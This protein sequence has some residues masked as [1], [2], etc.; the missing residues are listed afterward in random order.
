MSNQSLSI[1][2]ISVSL[3]SHTFD[4][5]GLISGQSSVLSLTIKN[6][7]NE[8][9]SNANVQIT[10]ASDFTSFDESNID[11]GNIAAVN[12]KQYQQQ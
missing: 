12:L 1:N 6:F 11:L 7:S 9:I 2:Q 3:V 10:A 4:N 8:T 5:D